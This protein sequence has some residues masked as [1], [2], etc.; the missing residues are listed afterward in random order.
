MRFELGHE[1]QVDTDKGTLEGR[2]FLAEG[3]DRMKA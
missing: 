3:P 1:A 2:A